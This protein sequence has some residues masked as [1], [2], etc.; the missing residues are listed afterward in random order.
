MSHHCFEISKINPN[1]IV[2]T[3]HVELWGSA[4]AD[5]FEFESKLKNAIEDTMQLG[6]FIV[7]SSEFRIVGTWALTRTGARYNVFKSS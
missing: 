7:V 1:R 3:W 4:H 6:L 2:V 5:W